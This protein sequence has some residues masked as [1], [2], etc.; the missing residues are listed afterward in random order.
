VQNF[1]PT[2][3]RSQKQENAVSQR[4]GIRIVT[5]ECIFYSCPFTPLFA[6]FLN[7]NTMPSVSVPPSQRSPVIP[8]VGATF[9]FLFCR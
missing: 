8:A 9:L 5:S 6:F 2:A 3:V 4:R 1:V 7:L